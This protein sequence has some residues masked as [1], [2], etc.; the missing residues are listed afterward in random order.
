M[1][2]KNLKYII[3]FIIIDI[4]TLGFGTYLFSHGLRSLIHH[5]SYGGFDIPSGSFL[6]VLY[7]LIRIW[8]K[9]YKERD[10][11]R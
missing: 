3:L 4:I 11:E 9:E 7:F 6:I 5:P 8:K 1:K 2:N 10:S